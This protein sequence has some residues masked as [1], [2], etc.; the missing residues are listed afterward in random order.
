VYWPV[1]VRVRVRVNIR[2]SVRVRPSP[3][4]HLKSWQKNLRA[5]RLIL[6]VPVK[7]VVC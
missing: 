5:T 4:S 7:N 6:L 1:R 3:L 2:V